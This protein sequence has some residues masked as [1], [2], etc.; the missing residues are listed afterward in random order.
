MK[1]KFNRR[2]LLL[3]LLI[4]VIAVSGVVVWASNPAAP[5]SEA[6]AALE[7]DA[8][9]AVD[10]TRWLEFMPTNAEPTAGLI[11]YPGGLVDARAYAPL[12]REIA[13]AGYLVVITPMPLNLAVFDL[14]RADTV[15]AAYPDI[16]AWALAGH[17]LGGAMA[18]R[19]VFDHPT[20]MRG[21]GL[22]A[23]YPDRDLSA[24]DVQV[25]NI[26]GSLDGLATVE[27]VEGARAMLPTVTEWV[28]ID[29]GNHAQ[30]GWYGDQARD[31]AASIPRSDQQIQTGAALIALMGRLS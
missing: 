8:A 9:V 24:I 31:N 12:A 10:A 4:P 30:F 17:S 26:Y 25:T 21:L 22:L 15:I 19:Y 1:R 29:G 7:S 14:N 28:K 13:A 3:L 5:M 6:L 2:W 11:F 23:A 18:A 16:E 20:A 27:Q